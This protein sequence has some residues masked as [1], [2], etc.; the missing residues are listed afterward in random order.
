MATPVLNNG[1]FL[2]D[3]KF[4]PL[5]NH[6]DKYHLFQLQANEPLDL[7][8]IDMW[9]M[10]QKKEM[11]LYSMS[12]F[13]GKNT[14]F[15]PTHEFTWS[16]PVHNSMPYI[17]ED[18]SESEKPGQYGQTFKIK[19]STDAYGHGAIL[20]YDKM[21]GL[22]MFVTEEQILP[23]GDHFIYTVKL[24]NTKSEQYLDR[25]YLKPGTKIFR[26]G[27]ARNEYGQKFDN[28]K[29][30]AVGKREFYNFV[31][32]AK[33]H[34]HLSVSEDADAINKYRSDVV[35]IYRIDGVDADPS[36]TKINQL[37]SIKG[38]DYLKDKAS[39]GSV[40]MRWLPRMEAM[41]LSEIGRDIENYLM[42]G[43]G[44]IIRGEAAD[45]I[46]LS[47]GL[48]KQLDN[49]Y[50]RVYTKQNF[51]LEMIENEIFNF[52][53]GKVSFDGPDSERELIIQTGLGGFKLINKAISDRVGSS[54]FLID[55]N[56][57]G[58]LTGKGMDQVFGYHYVGYKV[59]FLANL[60]FVINSAFDN[61]NNNDI[62]NPI[63]DGHPLTS[64]SFIIYDFNYEQGSDNIFLLKYAPGGDRREADVMWNFQQGTRP[65]LGIS[66]A[67][68]F[69]SSGNFNGFVVNMWQRMP[70]I[71]VKDPTKVLKI[72]MRN[73]ITGGS[74]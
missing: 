57:S 5:G 19:L 15:T 48:W 47:V 69:Q 49:G 45:D 2:R 28:F 31:G 1:I 29:G 74:F 41:A 13:G 11:P 9:A 26:V 35:E 30:N 24:V 54:G 40:S 43:K 8:V 64:Y 68:G 58:A 39:Q 44:G 65:Y 62:E 32:E 25:K 27:S 46:R 22:E 67:K 34:K 12:S 23:A 72:V 4:Q 52:F 33:A 70:A 3:T 42:W 50:K 10:L 60:R 59:P 63:I 61:V 18:I 6:I 21:N 56:T 73:P 17:V 71:W 51:S 16:I 14:I 7:G 66:A 55:A 38:A 36:I 20:T 53:N 37:A